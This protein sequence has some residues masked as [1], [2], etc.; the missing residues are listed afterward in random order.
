MCAVD[1]CSP[2]SFQLTGTGAELCQRTQSTLHSKLMH[3]VRRS[4]RS[5]GLVAVDFPS[6]QSAMRDLA[7]FCHT[8]ALGFSFFRDHPVS[9]RPSADECVTWQ[10]HPQ[11]N[12]HLPFWFQRD[13]APRMVQYLEVMSIFFHRRLYP[14]YTQ[15]IEKAMELESNN[16]EFL[17]TAVSERRVADQAARCNTVPHETPNPFFAF[18][19]LNVR[20]A[21]C[22]RRRTYVAFLL[23]GR[24]AMYHRLHERWNGC[25]ST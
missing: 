3:L 22:V 9:T 19:L 17:F 24:T 1:R 6:E 14:V 4:V 13:G 23:V 2:I 18:A 5:F 15:D 16:P 12:G 10:C 8:M 21:G 11:R 7:S 20:R 25:L